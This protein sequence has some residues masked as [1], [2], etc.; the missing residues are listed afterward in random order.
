VNPT[1]DATPTRLAV[2]A[3]TLALTGCST[4]DGLFS[5][6]KTDYK[7]TA[8]RSKPLEVPPDLTQLAKESRYQPQGGVISASGVQN[9]ASAAPTTLQANGMVAP[10][11]LGELRIERA[12]Q[13]RWLVSKQTPEQIW[14]LL[15]GYLEQRGLVL[16][17]A[18]QQT[19]ILETD[20]AENRGKQP[21]TDL[22]RNT[23]GKLFSGLY[24][25]GLRD[26]YR[27]RVERIATGSEV[28]VSHRG[29]EEVYTS[30]RKDSTAWRGRPADPQLEA[31]MLT[32]LLVALGSRPEA[33]APAVA[34]AAEAPSKV[35]VAAASQAS[36]LVIDEPFDR[37][38][39]RVGLVLDRGGFT[40]EDRDRASGLYYV[41]YIDPKSMD[42]D[43]PGWWSRLWGDGKNPKAAL[44]YR[45]VLKG[46]GS[47]TNLS[48]QTSTGAPDTGDN[49][50]RI[51]GL[52]VNELR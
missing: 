15:K 20:W 16:T 44:R 18:D 35:A 1:R 17:V 26:R 32:G 48:V 19:G 29:L 33:A 24:D 9:P 11:A 14:P 45:L 46:E 22:I 13:Q 2:L 27:L 51:V 21:S 6:D 49:A 8:A 3:L 23:I 7:S 41:R 28:Y 50:K 30:E 31:E 37:A 38:W 34:A 4:I 36:S 42:K 5:G 43:E 12:G 40:V 10:D 39:R 52:L 25:S 47:K